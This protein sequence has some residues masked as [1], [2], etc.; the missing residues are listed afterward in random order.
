[1]SDRKIV[2]DPARSSKELLAFMRWVAKQKR[3]PK[4]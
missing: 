1:M 2:V 3:K 4:E